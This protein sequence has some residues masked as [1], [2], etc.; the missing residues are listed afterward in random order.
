[1]IYYDGSDPRKMHNYYPYLYNKAIYDLL[2]EK[3]GRGSACVFSRSATVG[4]QQFPVNWGG[5]N[6]SSYIS[7][8]ETLRGGLSFSQSGYGFWAHDISGFVGTATPDLY[9]RWVAFGLLSSHSRLHGEESY[10][11][12]WYFGEECCEVLKFFTDLKCALMPYLYA[13]ANKVHIEGIPMM[14]SMM[15]EFPGVIYPTQKQT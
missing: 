1:M 4:T 5:D 7:M 3:N 11:A 2:E 15:M 10:R 8:A 13:Q 14:R 12:P 6:E 9:N